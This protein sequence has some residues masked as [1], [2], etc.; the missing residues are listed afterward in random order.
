MLAD[1]GL[2]GHQFAVHIYL[3]VLLGHPGQ[4]GLQQVT[5]VALPQIQ[6]D[7]AG[8]GIPVQGPDVEAGGHVVEQVIKQAGSAR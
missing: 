3:D 4:L 7:P 1:L 2:Q 8:Q 5:A 6:R